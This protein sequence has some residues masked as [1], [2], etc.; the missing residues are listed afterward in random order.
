[1]LMQEQ[2]QI[3]KSSG[4]FISLTIHA[5]LVA[6]LF[7]AL[8]E[9]RLADNFFTRQSLISKDMKDKK[10]EKD[11]TKADA[12]PS[13]PAKP[14]EKTKPPLNQPFVVPAPVV[15]YGNQAM[16]NKPVPVSGHSEGKSAF[17]HTPSTLPT[18]PAPAIA[19]ERTPSIAAPSLISK[20][21][22]NKK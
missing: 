11:S 9:K 22:K 21:M 12:N 16:M 18:P 2:K 8:T 7:L 6:L 10:A 17:E 1:M 19:P 20:E 15:F 13:S 5:V 4:V 3:K 14:E